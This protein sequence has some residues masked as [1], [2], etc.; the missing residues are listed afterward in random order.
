MSIDNREN[1]LQTPTPKGRLVYSLYD[2]TVHFLQ[3]NSG[4]SVITILFNTDMSD[5]CYNPIL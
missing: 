3:V 5:K 4:F 1:C 2:G